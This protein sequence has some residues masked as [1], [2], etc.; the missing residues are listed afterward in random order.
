MTLFSEM[1]KK[2]RREAGFISAYSYYHDNGGKTVFRFSY[3]M[4]LLI[5][6]G[7]IL[8]PHGSIPV[9]L[10]TL[11]LLYGTHSAIKLTLA[12]IRVRFGEEIYKQLLEP[13]LKEIQPPSISSPLHR[14]IHKSL[15]GEKVYIS[16]EQLEVMAKN[17][18]HY[19][20][21]LTISKDTGK[22]TAQQLAKEIKVNAAAAASALKDLAK[23]KLIKETSPG[24]Y[25]CHLTGAML[26][27]PRPNVSTTA[28]KL[29][30][31]RESLIAEGEE[32]YSRRGLIRADTDEFMNFLPLMALNL[33]AAHAYGIT[34][35]T[36]KSAIFGV[37]IRAVKIRDF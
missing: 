9:L 21:W 33:S 6:Q 22:W 34:K 29:R 37:E 11:R 16:P 1:L 15:S 32:L 25:K 4:Y 20:C 35:R 8:P 31:M 12:W 5:E 30:Q 26:E 13:L 2:Y 19:L 36:A 10:H 3:R 17:K 14:V 7:K 27:I 18:S 24:K 23:V 28:R